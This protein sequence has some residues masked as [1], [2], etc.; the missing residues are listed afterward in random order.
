MKIFAGVDEVGRG[1]LIGP[2]YA[3]AVILNNSIDKRLLKDSK[4]LT[5]DKRE[6]LEK[7]INRNIAIPIP[8][9]FASI[10]N[11]EPSNF[12]AI[13]PIRVQIPSKAIPYMTILKVTHIN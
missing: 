7:Y 1:S 4:T 3:A 12:P 11:K 10:P 9:T 2:V 8:P 5:K 6:E 13:K